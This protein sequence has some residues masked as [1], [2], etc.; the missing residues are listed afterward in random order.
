MRRHS[1]PLIPLLMGAVAVLSGCSDPFMWAGTW[2]ASGV[3][4]DNLHAMVAD[5]GDMDWGQ[6]QPGSEG[7]SA[8]AAV[9]RLRLGQPTPLAGDSISK[10]GSGATPAPVAPSLTPQAGGS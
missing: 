8:A 6:S 7:Q 1:L 4:S 3:N 5:P 2:H 9:V 10:V